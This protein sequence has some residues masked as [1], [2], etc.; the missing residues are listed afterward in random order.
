[1]LLVVFP[2]AY[3]FGSVGVSVGSFAI[4]LVVEP[5]TLVHIAI[6]MVQ[7]AVAIGLIIL[8][9][10][11]VATA[12]D[13]DLS[14]LTMAHP[15]E[16]LA[17]IGDSIFELDLVEVYR[18]F[19]KGRLDEFVVTLIF[20]FHDDAGDDLLLILAG[21]DRPLTRG[22][23]AILRAILLFLVV[24]LGQGLHLGWLPGG[25]FGRHR[26]L[27]WCGRLVFLGLESRVTGFVG[28]FFRRFGDCARLF[29]R[30]LTGL[31]AA[32]FC[33]LLGAVERLQ[34]FLDG[35]VLV[36]DLEAGAW[37]FRNASTGCDA[38]THPMEYQINYDEISS[39]GKNCIFCLFPSK[40]ST[41][42]TLLSF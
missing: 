32:A 18:L 35:F 40:L 26:N 14:S 13:P 21:L 29:Y 12:V 6:G 17:L 37:S 23:L 27:C 9:L 16:P 11:H 5:L 19:A 30:G 31:L 42:Q 38:I 28:V 22:S 10:T 3:V 7:L 2:L 41:L 15:I 34:L 25:I 36:A 39:N 33:W 24:T 8:P 1:M 20:G 4:G